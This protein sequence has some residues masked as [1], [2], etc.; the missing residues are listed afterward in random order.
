MSVPVH[1][2]QHLL[3]VCKKK[4]TRPPDPSFDPQET[5]NTQLI[6]SGLTRP[7]FFSVW[8]RQI[9]SYVHN[10]KFLWYLKM[11]GMQESFTATWIRAF[12]APWFFFCNWQNK[13]N[14]SSSDM[15]QICCRENGVSESYD[16]YCCQTGSLRCR[17]VFSF[18]Q[19]FAML[20]WHFFQHL[21]IDCLA[22]FKGKL[23]SKIISSDMKDFFP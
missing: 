22:R 5:P 4:M 12:D 2:D 21:S 13:T 20:L 6:S 23:H 3:T 8:R 7:F 17:S 10:F 14:G 1:V 9:R 11:K 18:C 19:R 15:G 16:Q